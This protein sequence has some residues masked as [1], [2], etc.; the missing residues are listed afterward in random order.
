[1]NIQSVKV[2]QQVSSVT[3]DGDFARFQVGCGHVTCGREGNRIILIAGPDCQLVAS[4]G[5]DMVTVG[6]SIKNDEK[7]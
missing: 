4:G 1:M 3:M 6:I 2:R 7:H 5:P